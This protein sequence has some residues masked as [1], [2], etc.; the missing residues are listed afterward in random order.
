MNDSTNFH[1]DF[2]GSLNVSCK[3]TPRLPKVFATLVVAFLGMLFCYKSYAIHG[4]T[5]S[6]T[7][8]VGSVVTLRD[9]TSGGAWYS[10]DTT[11]ASVNDSGVVTGVNAGVTIIKYIATGDTMAHSI[12]VNPAPSAIIRSYTT[13]CQY[14][15]SITISDTTSGGHWS[16]TPEFDTTRA[17]YISS[18]GDTI[19]VSFDRA[20]LTILSYTL[21]TGC[22]ATAVETVLP[23]PLIEYLTNSVCVGD[24]IP[25]YYT[26]SSATILGGLWYSF[27]PYYVGMG[28]IDTTTVS[29]TL[30]LL[31]LVSGVWDIA[32]QYPDGCVVATAIV[33]NAAPTTITGTNHVCAGD[34]VLVADTSSGGAWEL[35]S[36]TLGSLDSGGYFVGI[37]PG[38]DT[39]KYSLT[40]TGCTALFP[41]T[42]YP[43]PDTF[44]GVRSICAGT[45]YSLSNSISGGS[46]SSLDTNAAVSSTGVVTGLYAGTAHVEYTTPSGCSAVDSVVVHPAPG[47][48]ISSSPVICQH[49]NSVTL[50]DTTP[51]GLWFSTLSP[52]STFYPYPW[53]SG[54]TD[55]I[56]LFFDTAGL[57][58][59]SYVT[60]M[61]CAATTVVTVMPTPL[62]Q[63]LTNTVCV[64]DSIKY[65]Y[66][67][68]SATLLG[69]L[70]ESVSLFDVFPGHINTTSVSDT[71][72]LIGLVPGVSDIAVEYPNGC[73]VAT[74]IVVNDTPS[75]I[76]GLVMPPY[77]CTGDSILLGDA[78]LGGY[79][80]QSSNL[81]G[82]LD[83][84]TGMFSG[85]SPGI[86]TVIYRITSTGCS[87]STL[88]TVNPSPATFSGLPVVCV[89]STDTLGNSLPGGT[90]A[91]LGTNISI[92]DSG[93][94]TGLHA[95]ADSIKYTILTTGCV[96]TF[97][98]TV[99]TA[100]PS[101][102]IGI[103]RICLSFDS[104]RLADSATGGAWSAFPAGIVSVSASGL[105]T[106]LDTGIATITY[107]TGCGAPATISFTVSPMPLLDSILGDTLV[108]IGTPIS[109]RDSSPGG[110][111]LVS[112]TAIATIDT[113][114]IRGVSQGAATITYATSTGWCFA[115][116]TKLVTVMPLPSVM[117]IKG[118]N[119]ICF[120][121]PDTLSDS[122]TGGVWTHTR[123]RISLS[124]SI[125]SAVSAGYDTVIYTVT[126]VCGSSVATLP[127]TVYSTPV[128]YPISGADS[129][130]QGS[131]VT[132]SETATDGAWSLLNADGS[133]TGTVFSAISPGIDSVYYVVSN[134]CGIDSTQKGIVIKALPVAGAI[135]L[136]ADTFCLDES[137]TLLSTAAGGI[138]THRNSL[139][140]LDSITGTFVALSIGEDTIIYTVVNSC[141]EASTKNWF[142]I[143]PLPFAGT[144]SGL[145]AICDSTVTMYADDS[146]G[147]VWSVSNTLLASINDTT[148]LLTALGDGSVLVSYTVTNL[149]GS[150]SS[151]ESVTILS[152]PFAGIIL[153]D[154]T[155]C[156]GASIILNSTG[157]SG[158]W[159]L[160]N[161]NATNL[162]N[163]I[164]GVTGGLDTVWYK[165]SN[166]CGRDSASYPLHILPSPDAGKI[167]GSDSVCTGLQIILHDSA[168]GGTWNASN[169]YA[170]IADGLLTGV[171]SGLVTIS[172]TISTPVCGSAVATFN[173]IVVPPPILSITGAT[174]VCMGDG[175][176]ATLTGMPG[177]GYW[178]T[179]DTGLNLSGDTIR[180]TSNGTDTVYYN[181]HTSVCGLTSKAYDI[182]AYTKS[183][184][185]SINSVGMVASIS[186]IRV[187]P[188]PVNDL[189][190]IELA[191]TSG[192]ATI[193]IY[194]VWGREIEKIRMESGVLQR[195]IDVKEWKPGYYV[196]K[197]NCDGNTSVF[198]LVK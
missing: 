152:K 81:I 100:S 161:S 29:D 94:V 22:S 169:S 195:S 131:A 89:G 3:I 187:F 105:A 70:W 93:V 133:L 66:T 64:G 2:K 24:S 140:S 38:L 39:I 41:I 51:G 13:R 149:C 190:N 16:S 157:T 173:V 45:T 71:F 143:H 14:A 31:G 106:P 128:A 101:A 113:G 28:H 185:D 154:T 18:T 88:V 52:D 175:K 27:D 117:G 159:S 147:G 183:E 148:G 34:S 4:I 80:Y 158:V 132:L 198:G 12:T 99:N 58:T 30:W 75:A 115:Y 26:D 92:S 136:P 91:T 130:C 107:T 63:Y 153:G 120:G 21:P 163:F 186:N 35:S 90:W 50:A 85:I 5:G 142:Y 8:C 17:P 176:Y 180:A 61:G 86:D 37:R 162:L 118:G 48:I 114:V 181:I 72:W 174:Y 171:D 25:F 124:D 57:T 179:P 134:P 76:F 11:K 78:S 170:T 82:A 15:G 191:E 188:N 84:S 119:I 189:L 167:L 150:I 122:A 56:A 9:S 20:G 42:I 73:V 1:E 197:I 44:I 141:G 53:V 46:W 145:S 146:A 160:T 137:T 6:G 102:I 192:A 77:V 98:V 196:L 62:I 168:T 111:W 68:S 69:G 144:V 125:V 116:T 182:T 126:N 59:I 108:C 95:G 32:L 67:D 135:T 36:Y 172:Y 55:Y 7:V 109:L 194:D 178:I 97:V 43:V 19:A 60:A 165:V 123:L 65:W 10:T 40:S 110:F 83:S 138:W 129:V 54:D 87:V 23:A 127:V 193:S 166:I 103:N 47:G 33:V 139:N 184:C 151:L 164:T 156:A 96:A 121:T 104:T 49:G 74:A 155:L 79:F 177:G 112:D